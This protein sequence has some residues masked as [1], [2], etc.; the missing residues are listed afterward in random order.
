MRKWAEPKYAPFSVLPRNSPS[1]LIVSGARSG[2]M[3]TITVVPAASVASKAWATTSGMPMT[4]K[5]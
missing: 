1:V 3:P 5:A 2:G 4:S